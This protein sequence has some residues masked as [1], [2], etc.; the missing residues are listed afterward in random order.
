[1]IK[2][3][4][5]LGFC[6]VQAVI[7]GAVEGAG[8]GCDTC[9][10]AGTDDDLKAYFS[11]MAPR[12]V[13]NV[14]V[15]EP[16]PNEYSLIAAL[17]SLD[18][19][20]RNTDSAF[21]MLFWANMGAFSKSLVGPSVSWRI[22]IIKISRNISIK[23]DGV[24]GTAP[25]SSRRC[26]RI[27]PSDRKG[28]C[29]GLIDIPH[30]S[31]FCFCGNNDIGSQ[32][33]FSGIRGDFYGG[34]GGFGGAGSG[35]IG[36]SG[37]IER[38]KQQSDTRNPNPKLPPRQNHQIIGGRGHGLLGFKIMFFTLLGCLAAGIAGWFG[39]PLVLNG[40]G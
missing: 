7:V 37:E 19:G 9:A 1:M 15:F 12:S 36:L 2:V 5:V 23:G 4:A 30:R 25:A 32:L 40:R 21:D 10:S 33:V 6:F 39:G 34:F 11:P 18:I 22:W 28:V 20:F 27:L 3:L 38:D 26:P 16:P 13:E 35:F 31:P 24:Y 29:G 14:I 8:K 17:S